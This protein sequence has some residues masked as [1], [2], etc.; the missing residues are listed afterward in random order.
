MKYHN[1]SML[2]PVLAVFVLLAFTSCNRQRT[3]DQATDAVTMYSEMPPDAGF[4]E[5]IASY[6]S[7]VIPSNSTIEIHLVP[8]FASAASK[9]KAGNLFSFNPAVKG[10]AEWADDYTIIFKPSKPLTPGTIY[11][12]SFNLGRLGSV[13]DR[14]KVFPFR[15]E[16]LKRDFRVSVTGLEADLPGGKTYT[17]RGELITSDFMP[18]DEVEPLLTI[19]AGRKSIPLTWEHP[20]TGNSHTFTAAGIERMREEHEVV[21][22]WDGSRAGISEKGSAAVIIPA[23]DDFKLVRASVFADETQRFE[24]VFSDPIDPSQELDGLIWLEPR[25]ALAFVR[26]GNIV[27]AY[28]VDRLQG[29]VKLNVESSIRND[30]GRQLGTTSS[31]SFNFTIINPGLQSV[32][33]GVIV[34]ASDGLVFPFRAA[35]LRSVDLTIIKIYN[36]NIPYF[37]QMNDLSGSD[38][39]RQY[40]RPVYRGRVDL[41][42]GGTINPNTWNLFTINISDYISVEPGE[43]YRVEIGM[44]RSY[45]LLT[46]SDAPSDSKYEEALNRLGESGYWDSPGEYWGTEESSIF[47]Q[48]AYNWR[49]RENPCSDAYYDPDKN[50][51]RNLLA[52][53][54]GII[55]KQGG[56]NQLNVITSD[57]TTA[58][59]MADVK[60]DVYDLQMQLLGSTSSDRE[61]FASLPVVRKPFLLIAA[62]ATDKNYLRLNDGSSLSLSSFDVAGSTPEKGLKAYIYGERDVWRPGDSIFLSVFVKEMNLDIPQDHPVQFELFNPNDQR[63][64]FQIQTIGGRNLLSF[65]TRT[66]DEAITGNYRAVVRIGGVTFTKRLRIETV[67][68]NRLKINL[69][70][71][72]EILGGDKRENRA[73]LN[74]R[75]LS[76]A[77]SGNLKS[78]VELLLRP[79]KTTFEGYSQ[80]N[81]DCPVTTFYSETQTIFDG[82]INDNGDA[83]FN[84]SPGSGIK[85]AGM[86]N[87]QFTTRVFE[88]G[89]DASITQ[90]TVKYAPYPVFVGINFPGLK[91]SS[92]M[93][94]TDADNDIRL[95]TVNHL[96]KPVKSEVEVK[97]FKLS[98]RWWWESGEE[99]LGYYVSGNY[100]KPVFTEKI[101]TSS[102]G[103]GQVKFNIPKKEW[104]RY[105]IRASAP[106]GHG[107]GRIL[108]V[109]WP[110]DYGMKEGGGSG[111]TVLALTTDKEKYAPGENIQVSFPAP[112][113]ARAIVTME[114]ASGVIDRFRVDTK[115]P[116]TMVNIKATPGMAP[117]IYVYISVI[118]PHAQTSND[119][120]VRLY[121]VVPVMVED[122]AT[123]LQPV[124]TMADEVRSERTFEVKVS[125]ASK[126]AMSYTLAVVDEGLLDLTG[127]RTPNAWSYFYAREALGVRTWDIYDYVLGAFG[128]KLERIFA[129]GG[130]EA[131]PDRSGQKVNRFRPVVRFVGPVRLEAGKSN[132]HTISMPRYTGAVRVMVVAGTTHAYGSAEK[133][134]FVR[135]PLMLL[136]TAPRV[137]SPGEKVTLPVTLF[138]QDEKIRNVT[139]TATGNEMITFAERRQEVPVRSVGEQDLGFTFTVADRHGRGEIRVVAEG[140]GEKAEYTIEIEVRSPNPPETRSEMA[141]LKAGEKYEK[142]FSPFGLEGTNSAVVE[143]SALP[144]VNL[145]K[146]LQYLTG[147]PHGCTEQVTSAA[148][149][150]LYLKDLYGDKPEIMNTTIKNVQQAIHLLVS[151]QM[152]GGGMGMWP[153]SSY[154]PDE[155]ITSYVGHFMTEAGRKGYNVPSGFM[156]RWTGYQRREAQQWRYDAK[157]KQTATAQAYRLYTLALAGAPERG[158]MNRLRETA[159]I[160]RLAGWFLAGAYAVSGRPEAA[161]DL[162]DVRSLNTEEEYMYFYYGG[163]VRD[164]AVILHTLLL[165]KQEEQAMMLLKELCDDLSGQGWYSTQSTAWGLFAYM[166]YVEAYGGKSA[167]EVKF[168]V[169]VNGQKTEQSLSG[170][171]V[172]TQP[173]GPLG[174][175]NNI[176]VENRSQTPLYVNLVMKGTPG[177]GDETAAARN[178]SM[179]V[180]YTDM[181]NRALNHRELKQGTDFMMVVRITN[182]SFRAIDN[183]ALTQMVPSGWEIRNTR[184]FEAETSVK[185][186]GFDYRDF[187]DD[188]LYTYFSLKAGE[189]K[190]FVAL[191]NASYGGDFYQPAV[192][193]E[194]MYDGNYYARV[195]GGNV[196]VIK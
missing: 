25:H 152:A 68:P 110:W 147:Y 166:K 79:A 35:N 2:L 49:E 125:E 138:V 57:I 167:D 52:T 99:Q 104:G 97:I 44:R 176:V 13:P 177:A 133:S 113:G 62:T 37:L 40:G 112:E 146:R 55:A 165:L 179:R 159:G 75:W 93:L 82:T 108:L 134:V 41:I 22:A 27:T 76:G 183:V 46:C 20:E 189:T 122:P 157:Y 5:Y 172:F 11:T 131:L 163:A 87:A 105:L 194:A 135:D 123:R 24:L 121:G 149:P 117:N 184:L 192:W 96:G 50:L 58:G 64:D 7:G 139:V 168:T 10:T 193:C 18:G 23:A 17:L 118:Q 124:I 188:R 81:F 74:A 128:G 181:E 66:P 186:S 80:Y 185:E 38:Y 26:A 129:I 114:N 170:S 21:I 34:P 153:G 107:T 28:P 31:Q 29:E 56:D 187:R 89:G 43:I 9:E 16:T 73:D 42:S 72:S 180:E 88:K 115:S 77:V 109:D 45:S 196:K 103:E 174:S 154:Q 3:T 48:Y 101:T 162:I 71:D 61:G 120:P 94:F 60:I 36:N 84:V 160:P 151:R 141:V 102:N 136:A 65:I 175:T 53:N 190:T 51:R 39:L 137:L 191:L 195:P 111:A 161:T 127:F 6:T 148:F 169:T 164:K 85:S 32:G 91:G 59:P 119:M 83:R 69:A 126:K 178:L 95:V 171:R 130:D 158:A 30:S 63:V 182:N 116:T 67:K 150:Q 54:I 100:Y 132:T 144:S 15:I 90:T 156:S 173:A 142:S 1:L 4:A 78:T 19:T 47:Y 155:W 145:E 106:T 92:R 8:E 140:G 86:L 70:F 33:E 98:Y 12:G 143:V 14:L